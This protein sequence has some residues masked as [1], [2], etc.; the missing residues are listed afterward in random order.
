MKSA[1]VVLVCTTNVQLM[2]FTERVRVP[3]VQKEAIP[4]IA[5]FDPDDIAVARALSIG[6]VS[7]VP[8]ALWNRWVTDAGRM[9]G[10]WAA[11]AA[12]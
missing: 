10:S 9:E 2:Y 12:D 8:I 6:A 11:V 4:V 7:T 5:E 3:P 1:A